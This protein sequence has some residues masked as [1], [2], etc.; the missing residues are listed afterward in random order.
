MLMQEGVRE[1][2]GGRCCGDKNTWWIPGR[3]SQR[4]GRHMVWREDQGKMGGNH[5]NGSVFTEVP[6]VM[7]DTVI[8]LK[9]SPERM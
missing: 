7:K 1:P 5:W 4:L 3:T 8:E 2:K 6:S 9:S